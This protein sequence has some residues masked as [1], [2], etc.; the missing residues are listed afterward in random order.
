M[1]LFGFGLMSIGSVPW[2]WIFASE[3]FELTG[4]VECN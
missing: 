3:I 4:P 2:Y 1:P